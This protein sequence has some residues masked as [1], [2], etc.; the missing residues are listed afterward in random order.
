MAEHPEGEPNGAAKGREFYVEMAK[1]PRSRVIMANTTDTYMLADIARPSDLIIS[2]LRDALLRS[3]SIEE[4]SADMDAYY[5]IIFGLEDHLK[6]MGK[7]VG[8]E[9]RKSRTYKAVTEKKDPEALD[10]SLQPSA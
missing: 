2:R 10:A 3:V 8:I 1:H 5:K 9:Y 6:Q 7:K 4:F